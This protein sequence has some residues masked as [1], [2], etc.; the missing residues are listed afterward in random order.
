MPTAFATIEPMHGSN[1]A[2][3]TNR[4]NEKGKALWDKQTLD[5]SL[6]DGHAVVVRDFPGTRSDSSWL[7][8]A[9]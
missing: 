2:L 5:Q 9:R 4:T 6:K 8:G 1:V 7:A 3:Y